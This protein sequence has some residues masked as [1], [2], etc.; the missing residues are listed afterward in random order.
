MLVA[1]Y[2]LLAAQSCGAGPLPVI[3]PMLNGPAGTLPIAEMGIVHVI[4]FV[5][6]LTVA[7]PV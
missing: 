3:T 4:V 5:D 1:V 6:A 7:S 2:P